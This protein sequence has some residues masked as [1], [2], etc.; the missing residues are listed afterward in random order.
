MK[1]PI[2]RSSPLAAPP[3]KKPGHWVEHLAQTGGVDLAFMRKFIREVIALIEEG[4][5]RDGVVKIHNFGTFRLI[6]PKA[7]ESIAIPF[8]SAS[9]A[10]SHPQVVF[11][12]ARHIRELINL[13]LGSAIPAGSRI[14]L[15]ALLEKHLGLLPSTL[16]PPGEPTSEEF[17]IAEVFPEIPV[18]TLPT[19]TF[20]EA[21]AEQKT[22][23]EELLIGEKIPVPA[24]ESPPTFT[25]A[26][27]IEETE[28]AQTPAASALDRLLDLPPRHCRHRFAWFAGSFAIF[29]LLLL[30]ILSGR[31]SERQEMVSP[32]IVSTT[33]TVTESPS[34]PTA[35]QA[36]SASDLNKSPSETAPYFAGGTHV[37]VAGDNLWGL[38]GTYYHDNYLWPNIY[39]LNAATIKNPDILHIAQQLELPALYGPPE[40]LTAADRRNLAEG[41]FLLYR[42]YKENEPHLAPF[43]LWAAVQYDAQIKTDYAAELSQ[44]DLAF[45]KAHTVRRALAER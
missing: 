29:L 19:F 37:V 44:D 28:A 1:D 10:A 14:S 21:G 42:Y 15:Q 32:A 4:L 12:P 20:D 33:S 45:L 11:Q 40:R 16:P 30:F 9:L 38:S 41:Y 18:G 27:T 8:R 3:A 25:Y 31:I 17:D 24:R 34:G 35:Q 7:R 2:V 39:R 22:T 13:T 26:E 5:L 6:G 23:T 36:Q 43:A